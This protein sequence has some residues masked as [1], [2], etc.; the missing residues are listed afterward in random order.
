MG[1]AMFTKWDKYWTQGNTMLAIACVFD[2]RSK[3][4]VVEYYYKLMHPEGGHVR[5]LSVVKA[6]LDELYK[7]Y[8]QSQSKNAQNHA[9]SSSRLFSV[10]DYLIT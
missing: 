4:A 9:A 10:L 6:C 3:L 5:F 2:P 7:E 1:K 8:V